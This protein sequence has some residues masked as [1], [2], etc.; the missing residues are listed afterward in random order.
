MV[1]SA[2]FSPDGRR[3]VTASEDQTARI[4]DADTA[5][6]LAVLSGHRGPVRIAAFSP[7]G[8]R[9]V[10]ASLDETAHIWDAA[11]G[12]QLAVLSDLGEYVGDAA[13]SPDGQRIVIASLRLQ[14]PGRPHLGRGHGQADRRTLRP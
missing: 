2:A 4:W 14:R 10:T 12:M 13:Y 9:I 7:D 5:K 11:S 8:R 6:P 1:L 3:I